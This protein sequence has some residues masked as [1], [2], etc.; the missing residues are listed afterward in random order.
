LPTFFYGE[1]AALSE[2]NLLC[3]ATKWSGGGFVPYQASRPCFARYSVSRKRTGHVVIGG[4][5]FM[6]LAIDEQ[7]GNALLFDA[8]KDELRE[9]C[10][11]VL[12]FSAG[13][14]NTRAAGKYGFLSTVIGVGGDQAA[15][16]PVGASNL[17]FDDLAVA[18][19]GTPWART[20]D[21]TACGSVSDRLVRFDKTA[22]KT[23]PAPQPALSG[24]GLAAFSFDRANTI[25][26]A[27][28]ALG[29]FEAGQWRERVKLESPWSLFAIRPDDVWIGGSRD[30][31]S[32]FDGVTLK[33]LQAPRGG[34]QIEQ[35]VGTDPSTAFMVARGYTER[36]TNVHVYRYGDGE[37]NEWNL[38]IEVAGWPTT[39]AALD[40]T[41]VWR[42]GSPAAF[43][44]GA[45]WKLLGFAA[46][47]VW[48]RAADEVYFTSRGDVL[49]YDGAKLERVYH[50]FVPIGSIR[51]AKNRAFAVGPGGLTLEFGPLPVTQK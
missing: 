24:R 27:A 34:R 31:F 8:A 36:D 37:L 16:D 46:S 29:E 17:D 14:A 13:N 19:D 49:R 5:T 33:V 4:Q 28:D 41:H 45:R 12:T 38:G 1:P 48:A 47:G 39:I 3:R 40:T 7:Y 42:S 50:G 43:W 6:L 51:G 11:P 9:L 20:K 15:L 30:G 22:W 2:G 21:S 35:V 18:P 10:G 44:D 23:V 25:F 26:V 32:H